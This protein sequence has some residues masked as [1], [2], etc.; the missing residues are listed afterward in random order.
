MS[1]FPAARRLPFRGAG[2]ERASGRTRDQPD[3]GSDRKGEA[4]SAAHVLEAT[5]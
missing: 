4:K 1:Q 3:E 5:D 2:I